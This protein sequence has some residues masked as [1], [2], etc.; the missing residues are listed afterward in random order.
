MD[1]TTVLTTGRTIVDEE[2]YLNKEDEDNEED[3]R[4]DV[5][6]APMITKKPNAK[7][8]FTAKGWTVELKGVQFR[9]DGDLWQITKVTS[10][11]GWK[12]DQFNTKTKA[13]QEES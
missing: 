4:Q 6:P 8:D 5:E 7:V 10:K 2:K 1:P 13:K 9:D 11:G 3:S 12:V